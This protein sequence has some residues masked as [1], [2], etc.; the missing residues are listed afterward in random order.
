MFGRMLVKGT[1]FLVNIVVVG[2][3]VFT[4]IA[5]YISPEKFVLPAFAALIFPVTILL[6]VFFV[7][8]WIIVRKWNFI[9]S[10][11]VLLFALPQI[12]TVIPFNIVG[13]QSNKTSEVPFKVLSYNVML[14]DILAKHTPEKPNQIIEYIL[15]SNA[16][17]VCMQ[18]FAVSSKSNNNYLTE[19]DILRIF[20]KYPYK[21]IHYNHNEN[22]K[23]S[24][25][26]TFS[27]Y[28][29]VSTKNIVFAS[30]FGTSIYTDI[31]TGIDTIRVFNCHLESNRLTERDRVLPIELK[32][33]FNTENFSGTTKKLSK[34]LFDAYKI[35]AAQAQVLSKYIKSSPHQVLVCGDF[36][37]VPASYVY[38]T[39]KGELSDA[40]ADTG[41]G[42]GYTL[43]LLIYKF[44]IDY[45]LYDD[46]TL[47]VDK[48]IIDKVKFSDHYPIY[49]NI[50]FKTSQ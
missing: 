17:I 19:A 22:W 36:N 32:N 20:K 11:I 15:Q 23:K 48:Q 39:I 29:I 1:M 46:S 21:H 24:G 27:K 8:F 44:R 31:D 12:R 14:F 25:I 33:D 34:K 43:N 16:D 47:Q 10:L 40:W 41:L 49:T 26:A 30:G 42:F 4:T 5:S 38:N 18:E 13:L 7:L 37:D 3:L 6:N 28:P 2:L 35:R 50:Y 9:L 45:I